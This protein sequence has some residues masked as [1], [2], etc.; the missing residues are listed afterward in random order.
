MCII[1][2]Y[3][4]KFAVQHVISLFYYFTSVVYVLFVGLL[5]CIVCI[6]YYY[7]CDHIGLSN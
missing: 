1:N 7:G 5:L 2:S 6:M 4:D 3:D